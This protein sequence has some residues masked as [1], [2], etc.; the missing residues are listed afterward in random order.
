MLAAS[1]TGKEALLDLL[2]AGAPANPQGQEGRQDPAFPAA[3]RTQ[4]VQ[5]L[6][7]FP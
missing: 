7:P 5:G 4:A 6:P 1:L 2:A 3:P